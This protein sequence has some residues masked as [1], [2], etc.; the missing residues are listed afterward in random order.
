MMR[1]VRF[2]IPAMR[3]NYPNAV[4][5]TQPET[6]SK[7]LSGAL[8]G[9]NKSA[10]NKYRQPKIRLSFFRDKGYRPESHYQPEKG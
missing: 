4:N 9:N 6:M 3:N 8:P 10:K 1:D 2:E 5:H 7:L